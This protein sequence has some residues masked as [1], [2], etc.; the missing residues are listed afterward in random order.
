MRDGFNESPKKLLDILAPNRASASAKGITHAL[1]GPGVDDRPSRMP[2][3]RESRERHSSLRQIRDET[4]DRYFMTARCVRCLHEDGDCQGEIEDHEV[5]SC[6][7]LLRPKRLVPGA[8]CVEAALDRACSDVGAVA[9]TLVVS[10]QLALWTAVGTDS[11][12]FDNHASVLGWAGTAEYPLPS[13]A[14]CRA[15]SG[16]DAAGV[17]SEAEVAL[18]LALPA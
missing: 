10:Q 2:F 11:L 16:A 1:A 17:L 13:A 15:I 4:L 14:I 18:C 8:P 12:P 5:V 3:E 6:C 7:G 9:S